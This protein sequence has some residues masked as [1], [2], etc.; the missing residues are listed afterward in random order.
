MALIKLA[1]VNASHPDDQPQSLSHLIRL[2][3]EAGEQLSREFRDFQDV[4]QI[5]RDNIF[6]YKA[7]HFYAKLL[8]IGQDFTQ[9][10]SWV[11]NTESPEI[12]LPLAAIA[13]LFNIKKG[14][15]AVVEAP[16]ITEEI[17]KH[18]ITKSQESSSRAHL[19][20]LISHNIHNLQK[21]PSAN[22]AAAMCPLISL[23]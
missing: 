3:P 12:M 13:Q 16:L 5:R 21:E 9:M 20:G 4:Q 11:I 19:L 6:T 23:R 15:E 14:K 8:G 1:P 17:L 22:A 7:L 18:Y 10:Q 2:T